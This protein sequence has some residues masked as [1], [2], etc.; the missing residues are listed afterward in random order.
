MEQINS[1]LHIQ[2]S[3]RLGAI[4]MTNLFGYELSHDLFCPHD[5]SLANARV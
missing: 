3:G 1:G 4:N 2:V 5:P